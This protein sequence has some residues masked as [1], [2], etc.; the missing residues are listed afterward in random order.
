ME[1]SVPNA[2]DLI[3]F[4]TSCSKREA[5]MAALLHCGLRLG[6]TRPYYCSQNKMRQG[7]VSELT[8][9]LKESKKR[10][11][12]Q[13][14]LSPPHQELKKVH[15]AIPGFEWL[16]GYIT[17]PSCCIQGL[18]GNKCTR[19]E[20]GGRWRME[21]ASQL[22]LAQLWVFHAATRPLRHRAKKQK[23]KNDHNA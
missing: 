7:T 10:S 17:S 21:K 19:S 4:W 11:L 14:F 1:I 3:W 8:L 20:S 22:V 5:R 23:A 2:G 12:V 6:T 15:S 18:A 16:L 9:R 13:L